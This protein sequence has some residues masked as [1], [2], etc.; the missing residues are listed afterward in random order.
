MA[1][2]SYMVL[3]GIFNMTELSTIDLIGI[4]FLLKLT[5][6]MMTLFLLNHFSETVTTSLHEY[7]VKIFN[8]LILIHKNDENI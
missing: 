7:K 4:T 5:Y 6:V 8:S 1:F 3:I 2:G